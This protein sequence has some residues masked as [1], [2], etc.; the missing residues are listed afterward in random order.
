MGFGPVDPRCGLALSPDGETLLN[1]T[2]RLKR[3]NFST[4]E[5]LNDLEIPGGAALAVFSPDGKTLLL[6]E[7]KPRTSVLREAASGK[8][9]R[10]LQ[11]RW[12]G[13]T[14]CA[15]FSP[16]GSVAATGGG[17]KVVRLWEVATGKE[18]R[19]LRQHQSS[20]R[21]LVFS[22]DGRFLYSC[23][24]DGVFR[25]DA[26]GGQLLHS[27]R[28]TNEVQHA[29][30]SPDG[31]TLAAVTRSGTIQMWSTDTGK[32]LVPLERHLN[33][34]SLG[35][36]QPGWQDASPRPTAASSFSGMSRPVG[37]VVTFPA[38]GARTRSPT[39]RTAN[40][41]RPEVPKVRPAW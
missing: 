36:V 19:Q 14:D 33:G 9:L 11:T 24:Q 37:C 34:V 40:C 6:G 29:A 1:C 4:G 13:A 7:G 3:W 32:D 26:V 28:L 21:S 25:W 17:D 10:V 39:P 31:K 8:L 12:E 15:A 5:E 16:D 27:F 35:R 23:G 18:L 22:P 20:I 2:N 30:L 38:P 41:W